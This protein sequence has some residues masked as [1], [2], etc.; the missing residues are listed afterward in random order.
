[1]IAIYT[2]NNFWQLYLKQISMYQK[3]FSVYFRIYFIGLDSKIKEFIVKL[4]R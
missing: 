2:R 3:N 4:I 1:M